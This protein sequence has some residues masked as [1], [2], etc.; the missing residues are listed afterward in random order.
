MLLQV[1]SKGEMEFHMA[2]TRL[3]VQNSLAVTHR[4]IPAPF[5]LIQLGIGFLFDGV[6]ECEWLCKKFKR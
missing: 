4:R 2:K 6:M 3:I 5:N 1:H